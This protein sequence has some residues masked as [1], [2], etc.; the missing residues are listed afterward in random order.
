M[1]QRVG[2]GVAHP[3]G[4]LHAWAQAV[5]GLCSRLF[6]TGVLVSLHLL[7]RMCSNCCKH[8]VIFSLI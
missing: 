5:P 7:P 8:A 1:G 4:E 3:F 6:K 2:L